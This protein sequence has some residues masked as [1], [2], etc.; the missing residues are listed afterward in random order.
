MSIFTDLPNELIVH[1]LTKDLV[2]KKDESA[3]R[4]SI[5]NLIN[6]EIGEKP[7]HPEIGIGIRALLFENLTPMLVSMVR[8]NLFTVIEVFEPRARV[9][10]VIIGE[11]ADEGAI[12]ITIIFR[13]V[14][15]QESQTIDF[16]FDRIR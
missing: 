5:R 6:L 13:L 1:P 3:V 2:L 10:D 15:S 8:R 7:F 16:Y 12:T 4:Q 9:V 11:Y 14:N